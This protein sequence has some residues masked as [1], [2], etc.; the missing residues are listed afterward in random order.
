[1]FAHTL[2]IRIERPHELPI[3]HSVPAS[4]VLEC[5]QSALIEVFDFG[6]SL[7]RTVCRSPPLPLCDCGVGVALCG[8]CCRNA[9]PPCRLDLLCQSSDAV[10]IRVQQACL[11]QELL[12]LLQ[13]T[14]A[15]QPLR[16]LEVGCGTP[17][18][19]TLRS[20]QHA[21]CL[22]IIR[23]EL[24]DLGETLAC[25]GEIL[26][27][28]GVERRREAFTNLPT[29]RSASIA[30][31]TTTRLGGDGGS[32]SRSHAQHGAICERGFSEGTFLLERLRAIPVTCGG[33]G[34]RFGARG[35]EQSCRI[36][37]IER[38]LVPSFTACCLRLRQ[39]RRHLARLAALE[40]VGQTRF[41]GCF[42]SALRGRA[43]FFD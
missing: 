3:A 31:P 30:P 29:A 5:R 19:G 8:V 6:S 20:H 26:I 17:F 25:R 1:M 33:Q 22:C 23:V 13:H 35:V 10:R 4:S 37:Q 12:G 27:A 11:R 28:E 18:D 36:D 34:R 38:I 9:S 21:R 24:E 40:R 7:W 43:T 16:Q 42:G 2:V 14:V 41:E 32:V 15:Q 39:K